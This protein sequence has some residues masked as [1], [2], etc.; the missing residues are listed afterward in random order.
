LLNALDRRRADAKLAGDLEQKRE[1]ELT[2]AERAAAD[3]A[4]GEGA[5][6]APATPCFFQR[7]LAVLG[8]T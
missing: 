7:M 4:S 1:V 5:E 8:W 3:L 6:S 2:A